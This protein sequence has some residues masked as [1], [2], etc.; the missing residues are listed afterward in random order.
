MSETIIP[1][2][3]ND[4]GAKVIE[5]GVKKFKCIGATQPHD[6]PHIYLDL[7]KENKVVCPYCSTLYKFKK[8]LGLKETNPPNCNVG[9]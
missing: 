8:S 1:H 6:H 3:V 5:L 4:V 9:D 2:F 7:G